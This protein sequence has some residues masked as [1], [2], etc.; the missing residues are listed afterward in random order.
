MIGADLHDVK[1]NGVMGISRALLMWL[2][3]QQLL[4]CCM[5]LPACCYEVA[6]GVAF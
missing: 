6:E 2:H 1:V 3:V 4:G 5:W